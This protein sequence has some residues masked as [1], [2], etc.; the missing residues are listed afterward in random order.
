M[1]TNVGDPR[2]RLN[3]PTLA[4][5]PRVADSLSFL[6]INFCR[7]IQDDTGV[8]ALIAADNRTDTVSLPTA[9]LSCLI[10]GPGTSITTPAQATL[11]RHGTTVVHAG[12]GGVRAYASTISDSH[13]SRWLEQQASNWA[14]PNQHLEVA[15]RLYQTRFPD[16]LP[17]NVTIDRL[18]GFEGQR[19]KALYRT[20]AQQHRLRPF[21]RNYDP[22]DWEES[23]PVNKALSA[24][25]TCLYGIVHSAIT[26]IGASPGLGFIHKGKA[27]AFVYD[28]ADIYKAELT[29]PLAF[30]LHSSVDPEREARIRLREGLQLFKLMPRIIDDIKYIL[31]PEEGV[32]DGVHERSHRNLVHLWDPVVGAVEAGRNYAD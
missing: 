15:K 32:E 23:D 24:A 22:H 13:N 20:H 9:A 2:A 12:D 10:L 11:A 5:I 1:T 16:R 19:M 21:K 4:L 30:S 8:T 3:R 6:Y 29:I 28:I 18:R 26:A 31:T 25:N 27:L 7:V 14:D 17:S